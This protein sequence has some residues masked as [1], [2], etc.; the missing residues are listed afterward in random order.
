MLFKSFLFSAFLQAEPQITSAQTISS[1][2]VVVVGCR[3]PFQS[4]PVTIS[5]AGIILGPSVSEGKMA[6]CSVW[7]A[8]LGEYV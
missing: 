5:D 8:A 2:S 6:T 4:L 7:V 1:I 3:T